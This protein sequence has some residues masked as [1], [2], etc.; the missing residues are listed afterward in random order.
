MVIG[1][2]FG[3][4]SYSHFLAVHIWKMSLWVNNDLDHIMPLHFVLF[5]GPFIVRCSPS[6]SLR[7]EEE[8]ASFTS[9]VVTTCENVLPDRK[10]CADLK[11]HFFYSLFHTFTW[12][13]AA[14]Q[15]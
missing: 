7:C 1:S 8:L 2:G 10:S 4:V 9:N 5:Y 12:L 6:S 3:F 11:F 13:S 14:S 15:Q